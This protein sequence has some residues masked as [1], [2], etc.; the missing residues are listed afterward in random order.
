LKPYGD[1]LAC[2]MPPIP[3]PRP[4][5]NSRRGISPSHAAEERQ[6]LLYDAEAAKYKSKSG[7]KGKGDSLSSS[8]YGSDFEGDDERRGWSRRKIVCTAAG[9]IALLIAGALT[10]S[11]SRALKGSWVDDVPSSGSHVNGGASGSNVG[12]KQH[13]SGGVLRS[14]GT[15]DFKRTVLIVSID[16][17][18]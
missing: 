17:L 12:V 2:I 14:N 1:R 16:G 13:F 8:E 5:P 10:N 11:V 6:G 4:K 9:L 18:R 3:K 7:H 15:H